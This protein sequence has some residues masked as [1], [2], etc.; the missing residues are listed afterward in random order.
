MAGMQISQD[1]RERTARLPHRLQHHPLRDGRGCGV[2]RG[3]V[4]KDQFQ[5]C[6]GCL[7][8]IQRCHR[9]GAQPKASA[10]IMAGSDP[11]PGEGLGS[12]QAGSTGTQSGETTAKSLPAA[13]PAAPKVY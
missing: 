8:P 5:R 9:T 12:F 10:P 1:G 4:G 3:G 2:P 6:G 7:A 13:K 11:Q